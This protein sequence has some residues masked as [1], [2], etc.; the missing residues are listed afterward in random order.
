M[1]ILFPGTRNMSERELSYANAVLE[2]TRQAMELNDDV[3]VIGEGV[4]DPKNI[5]GT[6]KGLAKQFG[7]RRVFDMP[8]SENAVTGICLGGALH[9]LRPIMV[10]QRIDFTLLAM[11]QVI[12]HLAK[13]R[14]LFG[15]DARTPMVIRTI[16]GRG[17][18]QG[19]QHAQSL[20]AL[21]AHIPGLRVVMPATAYDA[22]GMLTSAIKDD[23]PVIFI[24]HR[25]LHHTTSMVPDN[26]YEEPV[27]RARIVQSGDSITI[28]TASYMLLE[29][30]RAMD[31][32]GQHG[33][34]PEIIDLRSVRPIDM[35]T[36]LQSVQ[37]TG[38]LLVL[39][40]A[41]TT[42]GIS[43]EIIAAV[44]EHA[45]SILKTEPA[46]IGLPD[47]PAPTS[48]L[49]TREYYPTAEDVIRKV[50][51][52]HNHTQDEAVRIAG[53]YQHSEPRDIPCSDFT[54]PF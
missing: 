7:D 36:I 51:L 54:G 42:C 19:P 33:V 49:L 30:L 26:Y 9:G 2:A 35:D 28:V 11:D 21:Y 5:F 45:N 1:L 25:W 52:M 53:T 40:T 12:N 27:D 15:D 20:Q 10:H 47:E 14:F 22:K 37:K 34:S 41:W 48:H 23:N 16:I 17:W 24:E 13:W 4:P 8:L 29:A 32:L 31:I 50:L 46:R 18:G 6:T 38:R 44:A 43:A 39:D 3:I